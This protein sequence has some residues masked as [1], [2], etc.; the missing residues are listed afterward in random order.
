MKKA[1]VILVIIGALASLVVGI[2]RL[3]DY[4]EN[5]D[6]INQLQEQVDSKDE[7]GIASSLMDGITDFTDGY[8]NSAYAL[9]AAAVIS[10]GAL[11]LMK[12]LGKTIVALALLVAG[13]VPGIFNTGAF[14]GCAILAVAGILCFLIK[15]DGK[16]VNQAVA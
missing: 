4:N 14:V 16:S 8:R 3:S 2:L 6:V 10:L 13:I 5:I 7:T 15:S 9:I 12:K 11:L 1:V